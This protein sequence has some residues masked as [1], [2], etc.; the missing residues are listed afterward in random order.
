MPARSNDFQR[1]V[2]LVKKLLARSATVTESK[3]LRHR[4][5]NDSRN[6]HLHRNPVAGHKFVLSIV[7][8]EGH[9]A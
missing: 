4:R 7:G 3:P 1:L 2:Y 6:G 9:A 5:T 8:C